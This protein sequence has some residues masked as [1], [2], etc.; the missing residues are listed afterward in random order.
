VTEAPA[1]SEVPEAGEAAI[2]DADAAAVHATAVEARLVTVTVAAVVV[3][4]AHD[5]LTAAGDASSGGETVNTSGSKSSS[6]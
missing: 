6:A 4:N 3:P 1:A 2:Q 5:S